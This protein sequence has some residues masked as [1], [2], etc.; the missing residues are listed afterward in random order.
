MDLTA[1][2]QRLQRLLGYLDLDGGNDTLR[3]DAIA[4]ACEAGQPEVARQLLE[5]RLAMGGAAV[6]P[7]AH[8]SARI[9]LAEHDWAGAQA[10]WQRIIED[11]EVPLDLRQQAAASSAQLLLRQGQVEAAVAALTPW[12]EGVSA[13][14]AMEPALEA[15][16]LRSQHHAGN[17][18]AAVAWAMDRQASQALGAQGCGVASLMA[19]DLGDV[20]A[21]LQLARN[22]LQ[23]VPDQ[24]EA[25]L[26]M[27]AVALLEQPVDAALSLN[28]RVVA[29]MPQSGRAW[30]NLGAA[31]LMAKDMD[32]ARVAYARATELMPG[33]VGSWH[34]LAWVALLADDLAEAERL[35]DHALPLDRNFAET[36][37][38]LAVVYARTG[39]RQMAVAAVRR[40][41]GLDPA[42]MSAQ[43]AQAL[44][45]QPD[46][47][48]S[49][50]HALATTLLDGVVLP[51]G[52]RASSLLGIKS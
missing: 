34:G 47:A 23:Q 5:E 49:Q 32:G 17:L 48:Q 51:N 45:D 44:L 3:Q 7:W 24:A 40:A 35:L 10:Q 18:E 42:S 4:T 37:G 39:R 11:A 21:S 33:H 2:Q 8:W 52:R 50:V 16:W 43:Y 26:V 46:M 19:F 27:G 1:I 29:D 15:A 28:E 22:A 13:T 12:V 38:S 25:R 36:H 14:R 9:S 31:R 6:M 41:L 30:A 20:Q